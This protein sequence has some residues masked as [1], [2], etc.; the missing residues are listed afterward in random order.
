MFECQVTMVSLLLKV[1][2]HYHYTAGMSCS[3]ILNQL[4]HFLWC[5]L[6]SSQI[7]LAIL[8]KSGVPIN[9]SESSVCE[10]IL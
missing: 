2:L 6:T 8:L 7:Y 5:L 3:L 1:I 4:Y 10:E 9:L